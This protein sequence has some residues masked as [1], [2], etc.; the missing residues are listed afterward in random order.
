MNKNITTAYVLSFLKHSW[1]WN[2]VWIFFYLQYTNYTGIGLIETVMIATITLAEIP[3]GAIGDLLGKRFTLFIAFALEAI[4]NF[5][6]AFAPSF[7]ILLLSVFVMSLGSSMYSGTSD[8]LTYDSL[9]QIKS[10]NK[11]DKVIANMRSLQLISITLATIVGG[12]LFSIK[13]S[14]PFIISGILLGLGTLLSI[15]ITEPV[16]DTEKFSIRSFISQN[17]LGFKNL[18]RTEEIKRLTLFL[19]GIGGIVT[20]S[21]EMLDGVLGVEFGFNAV[22]FSILS[23]VIYLTAS[24]GSQFTS[25]VAKKFGILKGVILFG[26]LLTGTFVVSP[27]AGVVLGGASLIL[28]GVAQT[29]V[30][31]LSSVAINNNVDSKYRATALSS[32]NMLKNIP[33]VFTAYLL[34]YLMDSITGKYFAF[35]LGVFILIVLFLGF[36]AN[37][38]IAV[39]ESSH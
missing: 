21:W 14:Y 31:N 22:S 37:K 35:I 33:Y 36:F 15:F 3:T 7:G 2:G 13:P 16:V 1:F 38:K 20:L 19:A 18:F 23:A 29:I 27:I 26:V 10:E 4:G 9:K 34:G 12:F 24:L 39:V 5:M 17:K 11:F 32:F 6:M 30:E 8:A 28:R 25:F